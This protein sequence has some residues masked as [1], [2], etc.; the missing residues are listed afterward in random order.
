PCDS[1]TPCPS[2]VQSMMPPDKTPRR[3]EASDCFREA[4]YLMQSGR[5]VEAAQQCQKILRSD[6]DDPNARHLLG[7]IQCRNGQDTEGTNNLLKSIA[8]EPG[9]ADFHL[10]AAGILG[11][12]TRY[13]EAERF[14]EQALRLRPDFGLGHFNMG[15][16]CEY[17]KRYAAAEAAY[18]RAIELMP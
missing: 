17:L 12:L 5:F 6:P 10:N 11:Q 16:N 14:L 1:R 9:N 15:V 7:L 2:R 18:R 8:L 3:P 13:G 4:A